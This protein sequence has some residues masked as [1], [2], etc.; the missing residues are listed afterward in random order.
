L[1]AAAFDLTLGA[2]GG[3]TEALEFAVGELAEPVVPVAR[4]KLPAWAFALPFVF[5]AF[6]GLAVAFKAPL[7]FCTLFKSTLGGLGVFPPVPKPA[8]TVEY[9]TNVAARTKI[10]FIFKLLKL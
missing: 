3:G 4:P 10:F 5:A 7:A 8:Y 2:N 1:A 6:T 9:N